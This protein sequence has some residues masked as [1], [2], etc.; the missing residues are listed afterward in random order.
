MEDEPVEDE[1]EEDSWFFLSAY[2][3]SADTTS[4]STAPD[5]EGGGVTTMLPLATLGDEM[6]LP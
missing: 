4:D 1:L 2:S 6:L 3:L 5:F